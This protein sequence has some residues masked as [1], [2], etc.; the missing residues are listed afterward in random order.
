[1]KIC[2]LS[3]HFYESK[4]K[5]GFHHL[6]KAFYKLGHEISFITAPLSSLSII[7][8]DK[9]IS[10]AFWN[11]IKASL[12]P[13]NED[14]QYFVNFTPLHPVRRFNKT[15]ENILKYGFFV[16][17]SSEELIKKAN[18]IVFESSHWLYFVEHIK[19]INPRAKLVYRVSDMLEDLRSPSSLI[20]AE[21]SSIDY[22]DLISVVDTRQYKKFQGLGA[23]NLILQ[24]HG[25]DK[26]AYNRVTKN[27]Y[28]SLTKNFVFVGI[29]NIDYK[30]FEIASKVLERDF[31]NIIFHIIGPVRKLPC[32]NFIYYGEMKFEETIPFVKFADAGLA[33]RDG[34]YTNSLKIL[35]YTYCRL[36]IIVP[37]VFKEHG[38]K[39]NFIYYDHSY[40][41]IREAI[42]K[43]LQFD[44]SVIDTSFIKSWE[45]I[46]KEILNLLS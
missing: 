16:R 19:K 10:G 9:R 4:R 15:F 21:K 43:A 2:L 8:R 3:Y 20:E 28:D 36:P 34:V 32:K 26:D 29:G 13:I 45:E 39:E 42:N 40:E 1:M 17:K 22:F 24:Y 30:F 35:Q 46:A 6:A 38:N 11:F 44:R 5:A 18:I 12:K 7:K 27:P 23:K 25:I 31:H 33:P 14:I 37:K 41:S